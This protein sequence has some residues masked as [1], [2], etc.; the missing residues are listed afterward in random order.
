MSADIFKSYVDRRGV[1]KRNCLSLAALEAY[2]KPKT[3]VVYGRYLCNSSTQGPDEGLDEFVN[4]LRKQASSC[5][6][7]TFMDEMIRDRIVNGLHFLI[8]V[9]LTGWGG[10]GGKTGCCWKKKFKI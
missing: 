10:G 5:K 4:R 2:F 7:G 3:S 1:H 6:F 8:G 9:A